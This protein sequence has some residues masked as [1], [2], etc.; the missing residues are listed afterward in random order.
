MNDRTVALLDLGSF[1]T[2]CLIADT[3][4]HGKARVIGFG[5]AEGRGVMKGA[6]VNAEE[7]AHAASEAFAAAET[8]AARKA[9]RVVAA[10]GGPTVEG[11]STKGFVPIFPKTRAITRDDVLQV[12]NHSRRAAI[13]ED[14]TPV[15]AVPTEFIVDGKGG[16]ASPVGMTGSRL[17]VATYL[18]TADVSRVRDF[19]RAAGRGGVPLEQLVPM[20][21]ASGLGVLNAEQMAKGAAVVDVGSESTNLAVFRHGSI[22]YSAYVPLG[23]RSVTKDLATLLNTSPEEAEALKL[24]H[25]AGLPD[26]IEPN[27]TVGILQ[28]GHVERRPLQRRV[29]CEII[30]SRMREIASLAAAKLE[31]GGWTADELRGGVVLAGGACK[32]PGSAELFAQVLRASKVSVGVPHLRGPNAASV[33]SPEFAVVAGLARF[34]LECCRD[35]LAP[36]GAN[37]TFGDRIR[38]FLSLL[39]S[40]A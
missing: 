33:Q 21:L 14:R 34:A 3:D 12:I 5:M 17:E 2:V 26:R 32:L 24:Q 8:Q 27:E 37:G 23:G 7:A 29:F 15:L 20:G 22:A 28:L 18:A 31:H 11:L 39:G 25:G 19:E 40:R 4:T 36:A 38:M 35:E 1:K 13:P 9:D 30:E 6:V 10:I 16:I